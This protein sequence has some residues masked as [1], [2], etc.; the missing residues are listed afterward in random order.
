MVMDEQ[1]VTDLLR[2][3]PLAQ[4]FIADLERGVRQKN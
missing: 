4:E 2:A 3:I 1:M